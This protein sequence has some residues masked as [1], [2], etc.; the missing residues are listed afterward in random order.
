[1]YATDQENETGMPYSRTDFEKSM[2]DY[3]VGTSIAF[4]SP[5]LFIL[6]HKALSQR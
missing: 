6:K 3:G 4:L 5:S 2:R 1:M